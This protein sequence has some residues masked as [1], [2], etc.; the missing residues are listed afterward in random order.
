MARGKTITHH[1]GHCN[2][3]SKME[4]VGSV[5]ENP[6][7]IWYRCTRCRHAILLDLVQ[8]KKEQEDAKKKVERSQCMEYRPDITY[9]VGQAIFHS[10]LDDMGRIVSKETTSDGAHAIVVSFEKLGERRLLE[11]VADP[12]G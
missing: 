11:S 4:V 6:E 5:E 8:W 3:E 2:R 12:E 9:S 10:A 7:R 1:C